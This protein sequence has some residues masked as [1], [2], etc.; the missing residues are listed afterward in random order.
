MSIFVVE[1]SGGTIAAIEAPTTAE[2][3]HHAQSPGF[4]MSLLTLQR[5]GAPLWDGKSEIALRAATPNE[6]AKWAA[7]SSAQYDPE[8]WISA[9]VPFGD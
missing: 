8:Q 2:A 3:E 1:V 5:N 6:Q 7:V 9:L 4:R